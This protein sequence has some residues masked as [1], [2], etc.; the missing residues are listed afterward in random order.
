M[1]GE[2]IIFPS[3]LQLY[4]AINEVMIF[5]AIQYSFTGVELRSRKRCG[6]RRLPLLIIDGL[7][8]LFESSKDRIR[9]FEL[10]CLAKNNEDLDCNSVIR[11]GNQLDT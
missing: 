11:G 4:K 5:A 7:I 3:L 1:N 9:L 10:H 8:R 6:H 2:M